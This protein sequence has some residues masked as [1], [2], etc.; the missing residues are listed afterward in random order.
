MKGCK[1]VQI[2]TY[3]YT[4]ARTANE[5]NFVDDTGVPA[6]LWRVKFGN[7][8]TMQVIPQFLMRENVV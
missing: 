3:T 1:Y 4:I 5:S 8:I 7:G 6:A 2:H